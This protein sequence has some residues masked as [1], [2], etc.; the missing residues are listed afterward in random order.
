VE[1]HHEGLVVDSHFIKKTGFAALGSTESLLVRGGQYPAR[2]RKE[3][4][5][6]FDKKLSMLAMVHWHFLHINT[7]SMLIWLNDWV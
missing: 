3:V 4:A 1:A 7:R 6:T 5:L 2:Q